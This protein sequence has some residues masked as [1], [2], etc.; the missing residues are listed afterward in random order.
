VIEATLFHIRF[1]IASH[2]TSNACDRKR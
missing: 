1:S 2:G